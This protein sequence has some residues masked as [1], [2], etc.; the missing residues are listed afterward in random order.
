MT[1][2][3]RRLAAGPAG[4]SLWP[5]GRLRDDDRPLPLDQQQLDNSQGSMA[6]FKAALLAHTHDAVGCIRMDD[7]E[8]RISLSDALCCF[9]LHGDCCKKE[10]VGRGICPIRF[11]RLP[12][13]QLV[14]KVQRQLCNGAMLQPIVLQ[15]SNMQDGR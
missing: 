12:C 10:V 15:P 4:V 2:T 13:Q 8:D 6:A 14:H 5:R 1:G 3:V 9:G 11:I 7:F